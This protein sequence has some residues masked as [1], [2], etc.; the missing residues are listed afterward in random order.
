MTNNHVITIKL[1]T[2][3]ASKPGE[4]EHPCGGGET[5]G[6]AEQGFISALG[7]VVAE[8]MLC[9][10]QGAVLEGYPQGRNLRAAQV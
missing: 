10:R 6:G 9:L 3:N 1:R 2:I 7:F 5:V 4:H 8:A